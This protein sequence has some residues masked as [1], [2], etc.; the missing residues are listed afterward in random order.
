MPGNPYNNQNPNSN[1]FNHFVENFTTN[2]SNVTVTE[3]EFIVGNKQL[4]RTCPHNGCKLNYKENQKQFVCPCH[5]SK[6][7]LNGDCL[8]G[9]ACPNNIRK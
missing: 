7:N 1:F 5:A 8:S 4:T 9:P 2:S 6:F 3:S